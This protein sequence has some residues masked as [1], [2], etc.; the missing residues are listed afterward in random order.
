MEGNTLYPLQLLDVRLYEADLKRIRFQDIR[1]EEESDD[2]QLPVPKLGVKVEILRY[3]ESRSASVRVT[4]DVDGPDGEAPDFHLS[5]TLEG[6]F[7]AQ[8]ELNEI[9]E[10]TWEEFEN[11]SA[12][13][14]I[15]P[16]AREALHSFTRRMRVD[17]PVLP[18]LNRLAMRGA[19]ET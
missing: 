8:V 9:D 14:L 3:A 5:F 1:D 10:T 4:L 12:L 16:Y 7:E 18:T 17:L 15:W 19:E 2:G 13:A 6:F 11:T